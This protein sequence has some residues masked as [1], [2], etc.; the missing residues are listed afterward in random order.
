M[1]VFFDYPNLIVPKGSQP[2]SEGLKRN[3]DVFQTSGRKDQKCV[4][5]TID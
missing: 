5:Q 1:H 3:M 2:G 4:N